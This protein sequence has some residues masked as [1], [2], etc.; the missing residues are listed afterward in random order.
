MDGRQRGGVHAHVDA[1]LGNRDVEW[2][3]ELK[4]LKR[5]PKFGGQRV[6]E[7]V[8]EVNMCLFCFIFVAKSNK[9]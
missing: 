2:S 8:H 5:T 3:M 1:L 7:R 4:D 6:H 9:L